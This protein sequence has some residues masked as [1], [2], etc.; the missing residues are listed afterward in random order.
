MSHHITK[1]A[2]FVTCFLVPAIALAAPAAAQQS[3]PND[4][5]YAIAMGIVVGLAAA[6]C[7]VG[8][9]RA[10]GAA[11]DGIC[12]NPNAT[13]KVFTPMLIGLAFIESLVIFTLVVAFLLFGKF[14]F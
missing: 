5:I 13:D 11:L 14:G 12:R 7:G 6:G 3:G 8:Q 2:A 4:G 1:L 10:A 9:G